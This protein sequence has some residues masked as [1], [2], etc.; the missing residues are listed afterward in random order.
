MENWGK[1]DEIG[2]LFCATLHAVH[3]KLSGRSSQLTKAFV[4][5]RLFSDLAL[6]IAERSPHEGLNLRREQKRR[7]GRAGHP[8]PTRLRPRDPIPGM[9]LVTY[10]YAGR[11]AHPCTTRRQLE[12]RLCDPSHRSSPRQFLD[13]SVDRRFPAK[14][15][16][17]RQSD[18]N[19]CRSFG[20]FS[21]LRFC[22][23][24][25]RGCRQNSRALLV[26]LDN[27]WEVF[28]CPDQP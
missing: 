14:V 21:A 5:R 9:T 25:L 12:S 6:S 26:S 20:K 13:R 4:C 7:Y 15:A 8:C 1:I 11:V 23:H 19:P 18:G 16:S 10:R 3:A 2:G 28:P 22:W 17:F 27:P 24:P